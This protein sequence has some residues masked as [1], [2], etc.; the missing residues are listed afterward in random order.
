MM[1]IG[2]AWATM[3]KHALGR[4]VAINC[5]HG[6]G[7]PAPVTGLITCYY[8][9]LHGESLHGVTRNYMH[10]IKSNYRQLHALHGH[11]MLLH[12]STLHAITCDYIVITCNY[13]HVMACN[14]HVISLY[15]MQL[16]GH[17]MHVIACNANVITCNCV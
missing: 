6:P 12:A 17:Y 8:M 1:T 4:S 2:I 11:Y 5:P 14:E 16:H 10:V 7:R 9:P 13:M 15:Y 3:Y